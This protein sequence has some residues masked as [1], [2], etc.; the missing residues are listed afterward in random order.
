[1]L[2]VPLAGALGVLAGAIPTLAAGDSPPST[3]SFTAVDY[4]WEANG[5][6]GTQATIAPGGTVSF[7]YPS[8]MTFHNAHF[9]TAQPSS[10]RQTTGANSGSVPP[11]PHMPTGPGWSGDCTFNTPGTYTFHCDQHPFM[12]GTLVVGNG[13]G[14]TSTGTTSTG[15]S[16]G[17][18]PP[19]TTPSGSGGSPLAGPAGRAVVI[20][21]HQ[22]GKLVRGSVTVS[23]AGAGGRLDV[24]LFAS[25]SALG[26][27]RHGPVLAGHLVRRGLHAGR[28]RF[29]VALNAA[30][31]R[32]LRAHKRLK[33]T[34]RVTVTS[35]RSVRASATRTV[36]L[37]P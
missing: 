34:V 18:P 1:M 25:A 21:A 31:R 2:Y 13:G 20:G 33:L 19:T 16:T 36:L 15:T 32:A 10:C 6:P 22:R 26:G 9:D 5:G 28:L 12:T 14:T 27:H 4:A 29:A 3:A 7:S 37:R 11:L 30:A 17:S 8:G 24:R 23:A 35:P